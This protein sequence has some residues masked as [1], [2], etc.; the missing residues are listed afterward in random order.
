MDNY[1]KRHM[2]EN[3]DFFRNTLERIFE[4]YSRVDGSGVHPTWNGEEVERQMRSLRT[5]ADSSGIPARGCDISGDIQLD[6]S[7][8][9]S[10]GTSVF[11]WNQRLCPGSLAQTGVQCSPPACRGQCSRSSRT[12]SWSAR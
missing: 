5:I 7:Q 1:I 10:D 6:D 11:L 2:K 3:D 12:R 8:T 4:K 9:C